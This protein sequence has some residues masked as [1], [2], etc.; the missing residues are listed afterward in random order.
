[1]FVGM[2]P[3]SDDVV[4]A[5]DEPAPVASEEAVELEAADVEV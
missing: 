3:A 5:S 2:A 4:V 1:M